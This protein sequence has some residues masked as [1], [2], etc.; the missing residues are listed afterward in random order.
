MVRVRLRVRVR[1]LGLGLVGR[2]VAG[3]R[4]Q[5]GSWSQFDL[6]FIN[7]E[8]FLRSLNSMTVER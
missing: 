1:V 2:Y 6:F 5:A 4:S 8:V 7:T 3:S